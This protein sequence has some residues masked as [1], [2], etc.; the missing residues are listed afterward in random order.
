MQPSHTKHPKNRICTQNEPPV[1]QVV[2]AAHQ[3]IIIYPGTATVK[4]VK[5]PASAKQIERPIAI[6]GLVLSAQVPWC[7]VVSLV[8]P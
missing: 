3:M 8:V 6:F 1:I 7:E 2:S 5:V 4:G